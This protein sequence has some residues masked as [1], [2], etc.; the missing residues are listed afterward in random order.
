MDKITAQDA[1][2]LILFIQLSAQKI[3]ASPFLPF[4][5][6]PKVSAG[7]GRVALR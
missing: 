5:N 4:F 2:A 6:T 3:S 1:T 7:N